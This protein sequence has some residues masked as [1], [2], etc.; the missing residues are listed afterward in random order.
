MLQLTRKVR[1]GCLAASCVAF[2]NLAAALA[3]AIQLHPAVKL[4]LLVA[5]GALL[6]AQERLTAF[7][8]CFTYMPHHQADLPPVPAPASE[9]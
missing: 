6:W 9:A 8:Q 3:G 4:A 7:S 5:L 2:L 1:L